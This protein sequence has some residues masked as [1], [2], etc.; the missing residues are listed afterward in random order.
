MWTRFFRHA[1]LG[2]L[3]KS[4]CTRS[5]STSVRCKW[6]SY[7]LHGT[8]YQVPQ[9]T[10]ITQL[11]RHCSQ[12]EVATK[13]SQNETSEQDI[14]SVSISESEEEKNENVPKVAQSLPARYNCSGCGARLQSVNP[15]RRGFIP[16]KKLDEW[17]CLVNDPSKVEEGDC[18]ENKTESNTTKEESEGE[19]G[20]EENDEYSSDI[21]DYFP[22]TLDGTAASDMRNSGNISSFVCKRC[23]SLEN[24]NNA[25]S[26]TLEQNDYLRH[27]NSLKDKRALIVL[28]LDVTDF[29][30]CIFPDLKNLISPNSS[31]LILANKIDLFPG[32]LT[33]RFWNKF[34][35]HIIQECA[36]N[37]LNSSMIAGVR[38]VSV[39]KGT[40]ILAL[41]QEIVKKWGN[42]G[43][44]YLLGCTNVGKS[45][46]F[47]KLLSHLC[48][49]KPGELNT[50]SNLLAPKATISL[51]PGTTLGLLSFPLMSVGKRRRL[52]TQRR[53]RE[54]K[55]ALGLLGKSLVV[56][57]F[58]SLSFVCIIVV[59]VVLCDNGC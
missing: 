14:S 38:F 19:E 21:Q 51:W 52:E 27:L 58:V 7:D 11:A 57:C 49:S 4:H 50:D 42:R 45:S 36:S 35:E 18:N 20:E 8:L 5:L 43:D 1:R 32:N 55:I 12:A 23:F 28:L 26:I 6:T 39:K 54:E 53:A 16:K 22:E 25:L 33:N 41:S 56:F 10:S 44:V 3:L 15:K 48:G 24:Y 13:V 37:G 29:P 40:G 47:N 9:G 31:V 30:S 46:L 17:L 59:Y 2:L 34:R